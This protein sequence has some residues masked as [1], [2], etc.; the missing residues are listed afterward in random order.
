M[1]EHAKTPLLRA[2]EIIVRFG[3]GHRAFTAV[4]RVSF[5]IFQG[6]TFGVVGES[7]SG[8]TTIGRAI[9]RINPLAGGRIEYAGQTISG[10][11]S[12][13]LDK[14]LTSKI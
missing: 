11:I 13:Q 5:D 12:G 10:K 3:R 8:K 6:E 1:S 2:E 14:Q 9:M 7:G 4:D